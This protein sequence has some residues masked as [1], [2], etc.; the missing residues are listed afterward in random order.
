MIKEVDYDAFLEYLASTNEKEKAVEQLR[1]MLER[2]VT[3]FGNVLD[4]GCGTGIMFKPLGDYFGRIVAIDHENRLGALAEKEMQVEFVPVDFFDF[5]TDEKFDCVLACYSLWEVPFA[6]WKHFFEKVK[7]IL[8]PGGCLIVIDSY[9]LGEFD[10][11][12]FNFNVKSVREPASLDWCAYLAAMGRPSVSERYFAQVFAD[13]PERMY[14][15]L[16]FG[17]G[18]AKG[19]RFYRKNKDKILVDLKSKIVGDRVVVNAGQIITLIW[20]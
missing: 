11:P 10:N 14:E 13:S 3:Q 19:K 17:F 2:Q 5:E 1:R 18:T 20:L 6:A 15:I 7:S 9:H 4:L 8:T 12:W 16:R